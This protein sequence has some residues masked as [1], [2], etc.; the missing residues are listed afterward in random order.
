M[1]TP[2]R[3]SRVQDEWI[4]LRCQAGDNTGFEDLVAIMER[5]L[6]YYAIKLTGNAEMA[7]DVLQD[8][9]VKVF[10]GIRWL[11]HPASL[12]PWLYR[13]TPGLAVDRIPQHVSRER[14]KEAH[15]A[16]FQESRGCFVHGR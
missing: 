14:A 5:P 8:V 13:I 10:R 3:P 1:N 2:N 6:L 15:V 7:L 16:G 11:K 4:A 9:W 12:R